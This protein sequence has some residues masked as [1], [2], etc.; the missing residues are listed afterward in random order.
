VN[1]P[2]DARSTL[3]RRAGCVPLVSVE[4]VPK[5]VPRPA[6]GGAVRR[7]SHPAPAT[8]KGLPCTPSQPQ[9]AC[10]TRRYDDEPRAL[11][12]AQGWC[13]AAFASSPRA[14]AATRHYVAS[15]W[16]RLTTD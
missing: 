3:G 12:R 15:G 6:V 16:Q 4:L 1:R 5:L 10:F 14:V 11:P 7:R 8:R 13:S 2:L 9:R